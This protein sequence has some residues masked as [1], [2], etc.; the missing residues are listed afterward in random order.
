VRYHRSHAVNLS[1]DKSG[2]NVNQTVEAEPDF[3][4][5][6]S[7]RFRCSM[8]SNKRAVIDAAS[9]LDNAGILLYVLS[10]LGPGQHLFISAVSKGWR[11]LYQRVPDVKMAEMPHYTGGEDQ[12]LLRMVTTQT[13]LSSAAFASA[14]TVRLACECGLTFDN[15]HLQR[16]AGRIADGPALRV[17]QELGLRASCQL[18]LGVSEAVSAPPLDG[19]QAHQHWVLATEISYYAA[20]EGN[21]EVLKWL[22]DQGRHLT[23]PPPRRKKGAS[24]HVGDDAGCKWHDH[25]CA[26]AA[27]HA[28]LATLQWLHEQGAPWQLEDICDHAAHGGSTAVLAYLK[29]QR[30][31]FSP[32]T[33]TCAARRGHLGACQ[34]LVA[35]QC[36]SDEKACT[37]AANGGHMQIVRLLHE[38]GCPWHPGNLRR[39]AAEA[40]SV[41]LL[42]YL[43]Q[44]GCTSTKDVMKIAAER[45][46]TH[47][48]QYLHAEQSR[49][50]PRACINAAQAGH[51]DTLRWLHEQGCPWSIEAVRFAAVV[52]GHLPVI[53]YVL[54]VEPAPSAAQ[55]TALLNAAGYYSSMSAASWL[56]QHGAEWPAVLKF[57]GTA[58][59]ADAVQWA[60]AEGCTSPA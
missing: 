5:T 11:E 54:S 19:H 14:S 52:S 12:T 40:G 42:Q 48:C 45:G 26:V 49:W 53:S 25:A 31:D 18:L 3:E 46:H 6:G 20:K 44:Q 1:G 9:L 34:Y 36:P 10:I 23:T 16:V 32:S 47:I 29:Q 15:Y 27:E 30:C 43:K 38:S 59:N 55:L 17:A 2:L 60:R 24:G 7:Y 37:E 50:H 58:W 22:K 35:E 41:E 57:G 56:R 51:V 21:L 4:C 8:S 39:L 28:H 33:L 13:T